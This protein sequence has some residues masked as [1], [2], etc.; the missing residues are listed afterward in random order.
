[1]NLKEQIDQDFK[2][3]LKEKKQEALSVLR[4]VKSAIKNKEIERKNEL[5]DK[6]IIE[7]LQKEI[8]QR[9][10][11]ISDFEK[12]GRSDLVEKEKKEVDVLLK[13]M[14]K[15]MTKEEIK[16]ETQK[17]MKEVGAENSADF[18]KVMG[19]LMSQLKGKA[20]GKEVAQIVKEELSK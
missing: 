3:A 14:P 4:M 7:V 10:E 17:A 5:K 1:M 9:K 6:E 18:G 16:K 19:K 2:N 8:K 15:Q 11:S 13:Y 20:D 12:G